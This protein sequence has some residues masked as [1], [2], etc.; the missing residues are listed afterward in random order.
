MKVRTEDELLL[1]VIQL[2]GVHRAR[3]DIVSAHVGIEL[4]LVTFTFDRDHE[5][6]LFPVL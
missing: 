1:D 6:V 2:R 3:V 5:R 4:D